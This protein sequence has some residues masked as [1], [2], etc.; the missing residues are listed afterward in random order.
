M[1][2]VVEPAEF[3]M[4]RVKLIF[5]VES[6]DSED[7]EVREYLQERELEPRYLYDDE[8]EGRKCQVMQFGGCYLGR[9]LDELGKIQRKAVELEALAAEIQQQNRRVGSGRRDPFSRGRRICGPGP[10]RRNSTSS[11]RSKPRRTGN[12]RPC[13]MPMR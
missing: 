1:F 2:L 8:L 12:W 4:H 6:P 9:H 11:R 5:D 10:L 13:W 3:F 7:S